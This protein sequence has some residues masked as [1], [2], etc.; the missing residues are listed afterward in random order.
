MKQGD[1]QIQKIK[2]NIKSNKNP[3]YISI[4]LQIIQSIIQNAFRLFAIH[5]VKRITQLVLKR[6]EEN[7]Q[8]IE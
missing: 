1:L 3:K 7:D 2:N 4:A 8:L 6:G 5:K